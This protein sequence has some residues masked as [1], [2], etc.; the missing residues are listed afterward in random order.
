MRA[1]ASGISAQ[2]HNT[3]PG[4]DHLSV[5]YTTS[6]YSAANKHLA[7][8][9]I[10]CL[11]IASVQWNSSVIT[12]A[13]IF[14][15]KLFPSSSKEI[16]F[17]CQPCIFNLNFI[18]TDLLFL[19]FTM[20]F[21]PFLGIHSYHSNRNINDHPFMNSVTSQFL[22]NLSGFPL[23]YNS[24]LIGKHGMTHSSNLSS[25]PFL[26]PDIFN[27]NSRSLPEQINDQDVKDD[28][29]VELIE[30]DLWEQFHTYGTEMVITKSGR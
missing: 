2:L 15:L 19:H 11:R 10:G 21:N 22:P 29:K 7:T 1:A 3:L 14:V 23:N 16:L 20:A 9:F 6:H 27:P 13:Y 4:I 30:R 25:Y 26:P 18:N 28:P 8:N 17:S 24:L 12:S 5:T